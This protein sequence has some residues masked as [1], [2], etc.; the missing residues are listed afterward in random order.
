M[1]PRN[2]PPVVKQKG[3]KRTYDEH[4]STSSFND[5]TMVNSRTPEDKPA[6]QYNQL[7]MTFQKQ[8]DLQSNAT[9]MAGDGLS[10]V[11]HSKRFK[12]DD[13]QQQVQSVYA[14]Q[15]MPRGLSRAERSQLSKTNNDHYTMTLSPQQQKKNKKSAK[16][17]RQ[18]DEDERKRS[19]ARARDGFDDDLGE[20][21]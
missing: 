19:I 20:E 9:M 2:E 21:Y 18:R 3:I 5:E 14:P 12:L 1:I 17:Q 10:Q 4:Q 13:H 15:E 16:K 11:T 8:L 6:M 7:Q